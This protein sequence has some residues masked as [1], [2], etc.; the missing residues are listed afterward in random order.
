MAVIDPSKPKS[1][2]VFDIMSGKVTDSQ[3]EHST[4]IIQMDLNQVAMASERKIAFVD[5]NKDLLIS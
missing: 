1:V 4:E 5:S 3:I 2:I